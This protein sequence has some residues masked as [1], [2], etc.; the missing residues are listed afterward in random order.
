[1]KF[2]TCAFSCVLK[3]YSCLTNCTKMSVTRML[4]VSAFQYQLSQ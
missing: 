4:K 1:M 3:V 2:T